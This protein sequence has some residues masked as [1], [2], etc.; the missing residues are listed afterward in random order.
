MGLVAGCAGGLR[1]LRGKATGWFHLEEIGGRKMLMTPEGQ[2]FPMFGLNHAI[3][4]TPARL[5][6]S[7]G[8]N[9]LGYSPPASVVQATAMPYW[10][11]FNAAPI[12]KHNIQFQFPDPFDPRWVEQIGE[13]IAT[14]CRVHRDRRDLI[15][16][17]WIDTPTW[18]LYTTR[19]L[20]GTDWVSAL[21]RLGAESEGKQTYARFLYERYRDRAS[22]LSQTY[23]PAEAS[24]E[25]IARHDL[26]GVLLGDP[27]VMEDDE[28]FLGLIA[29]QYYAVMGR[30]FRRHDPHHLLFGDNYLV[31]DHPRVVIEQ[32]RRHIDALSVQPGDSYTPLCPPSDVFPR[33]FIA[34]LHADTGLPVLIGDHQ[35]AFP[36]ATQPRTIWTQRDSETAA[37]EATEA[38]IIRAFEEPYIVGYSRCQYRDAPGTARGARRGLVDVGGRPYEKMVRAHQRAFGTVRQRLN[39]RG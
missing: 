33:D 10:V 24:V 13:R 15:G 16:Y 23:G 26:A 39:M 25:A 8:F 34:R 37:A 2:G 5:V 4:E 19:G 6:R 31:G 3:A 38:F 18:D 14:V 21:R 7:W 29:K 11:H 12:A 20:R 27:V 28:V 32:A 22:L 35:V 36:T 17:V 9:A 1:A 30:E